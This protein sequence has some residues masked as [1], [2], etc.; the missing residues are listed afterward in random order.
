[1]KAK[2]TKKGLRKKGRFFI[3]KI[4]LL[5]RS[6]FGSKSE[7]QIKPLNSSSK[8]SSISSKAL[9]SIFCEPINRESKINSIWAANLRAVGGKSV[10]K[11]LLDRNLIKSTYTVP[12]GI[13][14]F[15]G[16]GTVMDLFKNESEV[17]LVQHKN[18]QRIVQ[19]KFRYNWWNVQAITDQVNSKRW[20]IGPSLNISQSV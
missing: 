1:M 15:K 10:V 9:E 16:S 13:K 14:T 12:V 11:T 8:S 5:S 7:T 18:A 6:L 4:S 17:H 19:P 20:M 2:T 3:E